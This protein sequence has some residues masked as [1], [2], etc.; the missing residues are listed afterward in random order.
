MC[1]QANKALSKDEVF[2]IMGSYYGNA[3]Y[4]D[5]QRL[6]WSAHD[7]E[8]TKHIL[9]EVNALGYK[10]SNLSKLAECEDS[11]FIP[12]IFE[13][14]GKFEDSAFNEELIGALCF[15][16]YHSCTP[17][18]L[19]LYKNEK[20]D[21]MKYRLSNS[22]FNLRNRKYIPDYLT[23]V[24]N[25]EYGKSYDMIM[26]ILCKYHVTEALPILI[27]LFEKYPNEWTFAFMRLGKTYHDPIIV[28]YLQELAT[29]ENGEYRAMARK[30]L[31]IFGE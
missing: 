9:D 21:Q 16:N 19:T 8:L 11:R 15:R 5:A 20:D 23:I 30:A 3:H 26:D 12:I 14:F 2:E 22:L 29:H 18:L 17:Q 24:T 28:P 25:D 27:K 1:S 13:H 31:K 6:A 7:L 4:R 10:F